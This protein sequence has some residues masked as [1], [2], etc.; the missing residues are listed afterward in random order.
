MQSSE[1]YYIFKID[2]MDRLDRLGENIKKLDGRKTFIS[3]KTWRA[4]NHSN[5][6]YSV[7]LQLDIWAIQIATFSL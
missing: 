2:W 3:G 7:Y 5:I 1:E 6:Y 4:Y